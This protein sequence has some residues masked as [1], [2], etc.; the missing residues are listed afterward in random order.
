MKWSP[1]SL[2]IQQHADPAFHVKLLLAK[3]SMVTLILGVKLQRL[4]SFTLAT[5]AL[6]ETQH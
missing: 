3:S 6:R 5:V 4:E 1:V 2:R